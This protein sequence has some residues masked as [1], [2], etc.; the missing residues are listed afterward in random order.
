[1]AL[2]DIATIVIIVENYLF[3][4][5]FFLIVNTPR[6]RVIASEDSVKLQ[7]LIGRKDP[8]DYSKLATFSI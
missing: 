3:F 4:K 1:M 2:L 5:Y 6:S 8:L 7:W